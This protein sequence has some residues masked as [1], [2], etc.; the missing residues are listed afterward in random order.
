M[1]SGGIG[2]RLIAGRQEII[3]EWLRRISAIPALAKLPP[4][5]LVDHMPEF[6]HELAVASLGDS[7]AA[8]RAY[9]RLISG[10]ALQRLGFGVE[11]ATLLEEYAVLRQVVL[12]Y[13]LRGPSPESVRDPLLEV[14]R[15]L[16]LAIGASVRAFAARRDEVREQFVSMLG[17]DLRGPLQ[18]LILGAENI[19]RQP[20]CTAP[21]HARAATAIRRSAERMNRLVSDLVDFARGQLGGGI[22]AVPVTC[23]MGELCREVADELRTAHP[24]RSIAVTATG[25]LVGSWDRDRLVQAMVNL[26]ANAVQHGRDPIEIRAFEARDR[27][28]VTTEIHN[29][30]PPIPE[31]AIPRLFEPFRPGGGAPRRGLGLGLFIVQQI[32]LAHGAECI[33]RST[34]ASGTTFSIE[35]PRSPLS[36]VSRPYQRRA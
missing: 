35:W 1:A 31:D 8:R 36:E 13:L 23:D 32:A 30:G 15:A 18:A 19:L 26:V 16:D 3:E 28:A 5:A 29:S 17:H 22:P 21:M 20:D 24:E 25:D 7:V 33:V 10:H 11:L 6:L 4:A 2:H 27:Q 34:E 9:E 12:G 14:D